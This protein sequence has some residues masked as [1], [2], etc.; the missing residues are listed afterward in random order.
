MQTIRY[1]NFYLQFFFN[2]TFITNIFMQKIKLLEWLKI[3]TKKN[4]KV[5]SSTKIKYI[6]K[7]NATFI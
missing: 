7:H 1:Y 6:E 2:A 4:A 5:N 3:L